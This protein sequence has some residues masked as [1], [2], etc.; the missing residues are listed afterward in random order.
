[1]VEIAWRKT[2]GKN[3]ANF[4]QEA[5]GSGCLVLLKR[6]VSLLKLWAVHIVRGTAPTQKRENDLT[7]LPHGVERQERVPDTANR[8]RRSDSAFSQENK[9]LGIICNR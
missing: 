5:V 8:R 9:Q 4:R 2:H 6:I 1:L 7:E 3:E